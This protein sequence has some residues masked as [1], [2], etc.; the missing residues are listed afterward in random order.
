MA[1]K[2]LKEIFQEVHPMIV[3]I[4]PD[5]I[6]D[7]LLA[8]K[9][10]CFDDYQTLRQVAATRDRCRDLLALLY[11]STYPQ[12]FIHLR[13]MLLSVYPWIVDEI[14]KKVPSLTSQLQQPQPGNS[15][16]GNLMMLL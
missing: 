16:K 5:S 7:V 10:I 14:D 4:N 3:E 13:F 8:K 1:K 2:L 15:G 12:T 9:V 11:K 6:I